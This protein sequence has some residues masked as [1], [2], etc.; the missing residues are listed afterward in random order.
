MLPGALLPKLIETGLTVAGVAS[1]AATSIRPLPNA[2]T[3]E[4]PPANGV[5]D[6]DAACTSADLIGGGS[7]QF[8]SQRAACARSGRCQISCQ[9]YSLGVADHYRRDL[10]SGDHVHANAR[11]LDQ[12]VI[13]HDGCGPSNCRVQ[14]LGFERAAAAANQDHALAERGEWEHSTGAARGVNGDDISELRRA[15]I[16][17]DSRAI[18]VC[19]G[20]GLKLRR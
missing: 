19:N 16:G 12:I 10:L 20:Y 8:R 6:L 7:L 9:I 11:L 17:N 14:N 1:A 18:A 13:N 5:T 3:P 4:T 2:S 15:D